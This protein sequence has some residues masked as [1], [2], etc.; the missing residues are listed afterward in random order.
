[1]AAKR[2]R[3]LRTP[4]DAADE[5]VERQRRNEAAMEEERRRHEAEVEAA[6]QRLRRKHEERMGAL[7]REEAELKRREA[8]ARARV[9]VAPVTIGDLPEP[10]L[11]RILLGPSDNPL[12]FVATCA[13]V[14][15]EWWRVVM[16][17]AAYGLG[18]PRVR[19]EGFTYLKGDED[20]R[21]RVLKGITKALEADETEGECLLVGSLHVG[22][23]GAAVLAAALQATPRIRFTDLDLSSNE[24]TAAGVASLAP[25]LRRPWRE[26]GL[27]LG[28]VDNPLGDAGVA[29]LAK[30]LPPTLESLDID[31]TGCGDDGLVSLAAALPALG[32]LTKL[33]CGYNAA[34]ARGWVALAGALPSLPALE[35]LVLEGCTGMGA[36]GVAAL[37]AAVPNCPQL[38]ILELTECQL[39]AGQVSTLVA[40]V[41]P[42]SDPRGMLLVNLDTRMMTQ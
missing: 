33:D 26:G 13:R 8:E 14:C 2:A 28:L 12:R 5:L 35:S 1:M 25:A 29:A 17:S 42:P 31:T 40:L 18:L 23:A 3:V 11:R 4:A 20:D 38:R 32:R 21:A 34:T 15:A 9:S 16:G 36:E 10:A 41:R 19:R 7:R 24:L 30:A 22:D 27:K 37:A 39:T 6:I